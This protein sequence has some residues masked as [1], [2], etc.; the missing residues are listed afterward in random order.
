[1][2]A[3]RNGSEVIGSEIVRWDDG[4]LCCGFCGEVGLRPTN[5]NVD[6]VECLSCGRVNAGAIG[7]RFWDLLRAH[8]R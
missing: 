8:V 2:I 6:E 4:R 1:M 5:G 3:A 7:R